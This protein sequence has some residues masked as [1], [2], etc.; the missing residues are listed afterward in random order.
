MKSRKLWITAI[1]GAFVAFS[2]AFGI[3]LDPEQIFALIALTTGYQ[4]GNGLAT[5]GNGS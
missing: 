1:V 2:K 3:D 4:V 5:F